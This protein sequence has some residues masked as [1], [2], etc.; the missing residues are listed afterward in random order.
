MFPPLTRHSVRLNTFWQGVLLGQEAWENIVQINTIL[1]VEQ[2][3]VSLEPDVTGNRIVANRVL[4]APGASCLTVD[5]Q[6]DA[7]LY[8]LI[9][10]NKP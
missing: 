6:V 3:G 10:G 1:G 5:A 2:S 9:A 7:A 4:C 8:N